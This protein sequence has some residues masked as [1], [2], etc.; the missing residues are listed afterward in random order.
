MATKASE[1]VDRHLL[2]SSGKDT[3]KFDKFNRQALYIFDHNTLSWDEKKVIFDSPNR[4]DGKPKEKILLANG[5]FSGPSNVERRDVTRASWLKWEDNTTHTRFWLMDFY[6]P[7][8]LT[9]IEAENNQ[10]GDMVI[11]PAWGPQGFVDRFMTF[12]NIILANY[13]FDFAFRIDDDNFICLDR[14]K[15]ELPFRPKELY[16]AGHFHC[17]PQFYRADESGIILS[18]DLVYYLVEMH[19][20]YRLRQGP[21]TFGAGMVIG[22]WLSMIDTILFNDPRMIQSVPFRKNIAEIPGGEPIEVCQ[23]LIAR[24]KTGMEDAVKIYQAGIPEDGYELTP[25]RSHGRSHIN[26]VAGDNARFQHICLS[27]VKFSNQNGNDFLT[28]Y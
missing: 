10:H 11:I 13:D 25:L 26:C 20:R 23:K 1:G 6:T 22:A 7:E 12:F 28:M 4:P 9:A 14:L 17:F 27:H 2:S 19:D 24:H 5:I 8:E 16:F 3:V 21:V 18:R 15:K